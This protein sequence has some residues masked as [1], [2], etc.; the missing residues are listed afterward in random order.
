MVYK[1]GYMHGS[2]ASSN[3]RKVVWPLPT[4]VFR[5]DCIVQLV[6]RSELFLV[7]EIKLPKPVSPCH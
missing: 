7:N 3:E 2:D 1:R 6:K 4:L 5:K